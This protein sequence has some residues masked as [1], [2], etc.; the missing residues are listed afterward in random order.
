MR[1]RK[2]V[3]FESSLKGQV[4]LSTGVV[5]T[6]Y[7]VTAG[8]ST[9]IAG[10]ADLD[11]VKGLL[12]GEH[13]FPVETRDG[14]AL[15]GVWLRHHQEGSLG[16]HLGLQI[17]FFVANEP[18]KPVKAHRYAVLKLLALHPKVGMLAH[19]LW[20][21]R[22]EALAYHNEHLGLGAV[23]GKG[24]L[25]RDLEGGRKT[26]HFADDESG[27]VILR[28]QVKELARSEGRANMSL[29][30]H[31]GPVKTFKFRTKPWITSKVINRR[32]DMLRDNRAARTYIASEKVVLQNFDPETDK[33]E[34]G[35]SRY[36]SL[37]FKPQFVQHFSD[38]KFVHLDPK[39]W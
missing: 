17:C 10:T 1:F 3:P 38:I 9:F 39:A 34:F 31:L 15:M 19:G 27:D 5:S 30:A 25:K 6:P 36:R 23:L 37:N 8:H 14:Q 29:I 11:G 22:E 13:A 21:D 2:A 28:G 20:S 7:L 16:P 12:K 26:F 4:K 33:L 32:G 35:D 18:F 24:E